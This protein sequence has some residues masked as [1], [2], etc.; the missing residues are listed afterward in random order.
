MRVALSGN[1]V[2]G[3]GVMT[4][5]AD[6]PVDGWTTDVAVWL[7]AIESIFPNTLL[8]DVPNAGDE[9]DPATG[10]A[11]AEWN[12]G[13][14]AQQVSG[15]GNSGWI[16][17]VGALLGWTTGAFVNGRR[18][19]GR[20]FLVPATKGEYNSAT[21]EL[22]SATAQLV[23]DKSNEYLGSAVLPSIYSV[24]HHVSARIINARTGANVSWLQTRK[25]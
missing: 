24:T 4:L 15:S 2:V 22:V 12:S 11:V 3:P 13:E 21:G 6:G 23:T 14:S 7:T 16:M 20:T 10:Q 18:L 9:I 5:Y 8:L 19:A 25:R 17:G 1:A